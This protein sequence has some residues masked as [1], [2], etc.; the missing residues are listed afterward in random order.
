MQVAKD[1]DG[2]G[3]QILSDTEIVAEVNGERDD[4]PCN[5]KVVDESTETTCKGIY[6]AFGTDQEWLEAE[7]DVGIA[8]YSKKQS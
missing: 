3:D 6:E 8:S 4:L 1:S 2:S 5:T 7:R